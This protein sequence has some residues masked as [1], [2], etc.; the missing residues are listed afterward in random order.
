MRESTGLKIIS[1]PNI[2]FYKA[3]NN[4]KATVT[5]KFE[6]KGK[7]IIANGRFLT[8]NMQFANSQDSRVIT[9][10]LAH[11]MTHFSD[12][13]RI[14]NYK[15][16]ERNL[17]GVDFDQLT[18]KKSETPYLEEKIVLSEREIK[19]MKNY[20][21]LVG[22]SLVENHGTLMELVLQKRQEIGFQPIRDI[23]NKLSPQAL[24]F[25]N[26]FVTFNPEIS[27]FQVWQKLDIDDNFYN[28]DKKEN[29]N[30]VYY[31]TGLLDKA[32]Q[33]N[34]LNEGLCDFLGNLITDKIL[35]KLPEELENT[36][37][38]GYPEYFWAIQNFWNSCDQIQQIEFLEAVL[39]AKFKYTSIA[40][41]Y[42]FFQKFFASSN[43]PNFAKRFSIRDIF[44]LNI[45]ETAKACN[46]NSAKNQPK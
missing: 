2:L 3:D 34:W 17:S 41:I 14:F 37:E 25:L 38:I 19:E 9:H 16:A 31:L 6:Y 32:N 43:N 13:I 39:L 30:Y 1:T 23:E 12:S 42:K 26:H 45:F 21:A 8:V 22:A 27:G 33:K 4:K 40:P 35:G 11:E 44:S 24:K 46:S 29:D 18:L 7:Q 10:L 20:L 28:Y 36:K 5:P 15:F